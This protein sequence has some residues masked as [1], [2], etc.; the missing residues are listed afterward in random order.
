MI[1]LKFQSFSVYR[2]SPRFIHESQVVGLMIC[3][4]LVYILLWNIALVAEGAENTI[5]PFIKIQGGV[6]LLQEIDYSVLW[7]K[8]LFLG[9]E[10]TATWPHSNTRMRSYNKMVLSRSTVGN[11]VS[12][13][14][15]MFNRIDSRAMQINVLSL[16]SVWMVCWI[17][18]SVSKSTDALRD[19]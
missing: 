16:N 14:Y 15:N 9:G 10:L 17:L 13:L 11:N 19:Q 6:E 3:V 12:P 1:I 2:Y 8:M 7:F 18:E 4:C 5:F